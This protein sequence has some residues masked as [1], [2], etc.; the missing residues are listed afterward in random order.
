L[1]EFGGAEGTAVCQREG[2]GE[3][4]AAIEYVVLRGGVR[5]KQ[6]GER[7]NFSVN[8]GVERMI[9]TFLSDPGSLSAKS[10]RRGSISSGSGTFNN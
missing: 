8:I 7:V 4:Q 2:Q 5:Q 6:C 10:S 1:F 9:V 3:A